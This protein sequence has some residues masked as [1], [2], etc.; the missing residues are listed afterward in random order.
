VFSDTINT[1]QKEVLLERTYFGTL[2]K[3]KLVSRFWSIG[4]SLSRE[5]V[6]AKGRNKK[7]K[8][9]KEAQDY[10]VHLI[11]NKSES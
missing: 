8:V 5:N 6:R 1:I 4:V 9:Y 7:S 2:A 11:N 10:I 3:L